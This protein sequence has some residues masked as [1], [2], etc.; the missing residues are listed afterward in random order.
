MNLSNLSL[1]LHQK[2]PS[3]SG[4]LCLNPLSLKQTTLFILFLFSN[5]CIMA[6]SLNLVESLDDQWIVYD[7]ELGNYVPYL[8]NYHGDVAKKHLLLDTKKWQDFY[9]Q[10]EA[11]ESVL[12]FVN[13][14]LFE[15]IKDGEINIS[16]KELPADNSVL[17]TVF[18]QPFLPKELKASIL[19]YEELIPKFNDS[20]KAIEKRAENSLSDRDTYTILTIIMLA[21]M[22]LLSRTSIPILNAPALSGY[23]NYFFKRKAPEAR[24]NALAFLAFIT[25]YGLGFSYYYIIIT[26]LRGNNSG[27]QEYLIFPNS[28]LGSFLSLFLLMSLFLIAR[29][30]FMLLMSILYDFRKATTIHVQEFMNIYQIYLVILVILGGILHFSILSNPAFAYQISL[31]FVVLTNI[32]NIVL[33][34]YR[35]NKAFPFKRVY[36]FSYLCATEI[37]P[38]LFLINFLVEN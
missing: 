1:H 36:L 34:S 35:I 6:Q 13:N 28:I 21:G 24:V 19:Q 4:T 33:V 22:S 14:T 27:L 11:S 25:F 37:L 12:I 23:I 9:L 10:V 2:H 3:P 18:R 5:L 8:Q 16:F 38:T 30:A 31:A 26:S 15:K 32:L 7:D 20:Q 29:F 17:L